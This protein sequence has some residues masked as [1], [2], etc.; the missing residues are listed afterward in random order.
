MGSILRGDIVWAKLDATQGHEQAGDRPVLVLSQDIFNARSG[1]VIAMPLTSKEPRLGF[2]LTL[3]I[4]E[5]KLPKRSWVKIAQ[6]RTLAT[7][8]IGKKLGRASEDEMDQV[9]EGL[10]ELID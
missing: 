2:P 7:S 6:I 3:E 5:A 9:I 8:R 1:T 4:T 10:N